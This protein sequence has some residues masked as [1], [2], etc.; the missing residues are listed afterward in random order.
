[1]TVPS[2]NSHSQQ[3]KRVLIRASAGTGKT[4]RL[5]NHYLAQLL[6]GASPD[7]ILATTF[8]RKAA[9]EIQERLFER[10]LHA[11][12][13]DAD[14]AELSEFLGVA[15]DRQQAARFLHELARN[16]HRVRV[17]TLDALF[18]KLAGAYSLEFGLPSEWHVLDDSE[19]LPLK[20]RAIDDALGLS[21]TE[22][23]VSLLSMLDKGE[24]KRRVVGQILD[25]VN[26]FYN[27][28]VDA[29]RRFQPWD[30]V[31][32]PDFVTEAAL[33]VAF[34]TLHEEGLAFPNKN[35]VSDFQKLH[36]RALSGDWS[37][38]IASRAVGNAAAVDPK[39]RRKPMSEALCDAIATIANHAA[40][41]LLAEL[42]AQNHATFELL[43]VFD[44]A[45]RQRK[46][47]TAGLTFSDVTRHLAEA[48]QVLNTDR[49]GFRLDGEIEHLLLDEFQDTSLP[50]WD[51][52]RP[53]ALGTSQRE[54][55]SVFCVGDLKQAIYGWRGGVAAIF[56]RIEQE[57]D[58]EPET[59]DRSFRSANTIIDVV[60]QLFGNLPQFGDYSRPDRV[61]VDTWH[62]RFQRHSA[63]P[64][65]DGYAEVRVTPDP[66]SQAKFG[67]DIRR[68]TAEFVRNLQRD[69]PGRSIGV[70]TRKNDVAS[71]I[72]AHLRGLGVT[73]SDEGR[74]KLTDSAAV[75]LIYSLIKIAENPED[76]AARFHVAASPLTVPAGLA[77]HRDDE[78][79][80]ALSQ[81]LRSQFMDDSFGRTVH[82]W[83]SYLV[84][85]CGPR[86]V[87]RLRQLVDLA[88]RYDNMPSPTAGEFLRL[89]DETREN[90]PVPGLVRV[91]TVHQSKGLEFDIVV[92]TELD[93][94]CYNLARSGYV[95]ARSEA[96]APPD[97]IMRYR[98]QVEVARFPEDIRAVFDEAATAEM[99]EALCRFY[100]AVT[101]A[102]SA[103][104]CLVAP[105]KKST[106]DSYSTRFSD[107]IRF[108][109][110]D[111]AAFVADT[112]A[113]R[114]GDANWDNQSPAIGE[115]TEI[116]ANAP[117]QAGRS[118]QQSREVLFKNSPH[119]EQREIPTISP[120]SLS[121]GSN[122]ESSRVVVG[123]ITDRSAAVRGTL[124]HRW[125]QEIEWLETSL[126]LTSTRRMELAHWLDV[127]PRIAQREDKRIDNILR[128]PCLKAVLSKDSYT[129]L[130]GKPIVGVYR[131]M[132]FSIWQSEIESDA[133][134]PKN[135]IVSGT[136]DRLVVFGDRSGP[137]GAE[138]IDWKTDFVE[139]EQH[140]Q[141]KVVQ[142]R[143]QM[144]SYANA[145]STLFEIDRSLIQARLVFLSFEHTILISPEDLIDHAMEIE[146]AEI[147]TQGE[148]RAHA[149]PTESQR[150]LFD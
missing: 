107:L 66:E 104:F 80:A 141:E 61:A 25:A 116:D 31:R 53:I 54:T 127:P 19:E 97:R 16:M 133:S 2:R 138:I 132:P 56:D 135:A 52:L 5:S 142:Y 122:A 17:S 13:S 70:L 38:F 89:V 96:A 84:D 145:V 15:T 40:A 64:Q 134:S 98:S 6:R 44:L 7:S 108:L 11:A 140:L 86:D 27:V 4:F 36:A 63:A 18:A 112:T 45:F 37:G 65:R 49:L 74:E 20:L 32:E 101:R 125:M 85:R 29:G 111:G 120:S 113:K 90:D 117:S 51:I 58:I 76:S 109:L 69:H 26:D 128:S 8:T 103:L 100:V 12:K 93:D 79:A 30:R 78:A 9:G 131:E 60:N 139:D 121:H 43:N 67:H 39:H 77:S 3:A 119:G 59:M 75:Q 14:A 148:Q 62:D 92:L 68:W 35:G 150:S 102:Q 73:A 118:T 42:R 149:V 110:C 57:L 147:R 87:A 55:G 72:V 47:E 50:Q 21:D 143:P 124:I 137:I 99:A 106:R 81:Q 136:I 126:E 105:T 114:F 129:K 123:E 22:A 46:A 48:I 83:A 91:M 146:T 23:T 33:A 88:D 71:E 41:H 24:S 34:D 95:A 1:M 130:S 10:L 82:H 115:R 94:P 28:Y 144:A